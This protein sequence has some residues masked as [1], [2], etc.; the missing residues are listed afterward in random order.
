MTRRP[1]VRAALIALSLV[2][3]AGSSLAQEPEPEPEPVPRVVVAVI[4]SAPNPYHEFFNAGGSLYGDTA[5]ASVTPDV[6]L[7]FG[8]DESHIIHLTRTGNFTSDFAQDKTQFDAI[9]LGEPYW[10][11]G[12]NV[13]GISFN[14][15]DKTRLR[16]D[17]TTST[18]GIGTSAAVFTA[19]P[20][21][22][23][24]SVE[25]PGAPLGVPGFATQPQG[26]AWAFSHPA[27]DLISTSY[28]PP[29]SPPLGYHLT[30][31]YKGVVQNG[32][33]H[34]GAADNSPA[35]SPIDATSGPWFTIGVAGYG[36]GSSEGREN[37]SGSL[38]DFVADFT[39]TLPYCRRCESGKSSVSGTSFATPRT[40]GT[41]SK[42][43]LDAR[44]EAWHL[45]GIIT[46]GVTEPVM[47]RGEGL[48]LTNWEIRRALEEAAYYATSA[49]FKSS[50]TDTPFL[51]A[52]PWVQAG[53]GTVTTDPAKR[54]V[55]EA[56]AQLGIG[57]P[58]TRSKPAEAC[59]FMTANI[60]ARHVWWD[61]VARFSQSSGQTADPYEYC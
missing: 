39:Q 49:E 25:S 22:I 4:D 5:P 23:V 32:K 21:A 12:T 53:W 18:H 41:L 3:P 29:G 1:L 50:G 58:P 42:I 31:A 11:E 13:I 48:D 51:D 16:P 54:V 61:R 59:T 56:L 40:A 43:I 20:E 36:E 26:E 57:G 38:P 60:Q 6:L 52:A 10:F 37:Q 7:E 34:V 30:D 2:L 19:N 45:R 9:K 17:T 33:I 14:A 28:G 47:V 27:V 44:R 24:V 8:I 46:D 35:L 55:P 15:T